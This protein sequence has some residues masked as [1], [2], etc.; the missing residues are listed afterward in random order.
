MQAFYIVKT[1][2]GGRAY[3]K[4]DAYYSG[5]SARIGRNCS[6]GSIN[7]E[8]FQRCFDGILSWSS[9]EQR[10]ATE[11]TAFINLRY[12]KKKPANLA[13]FFLRGQVSF[14]FP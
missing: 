5:R 6:I 14:L 11:L 10:R 4:T 2:I 1:H 3:L 13:G 12:I 8:P 7:R 9:R